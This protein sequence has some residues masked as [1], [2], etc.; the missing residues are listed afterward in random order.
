MLDD[1]SPLERV[2][3]LVTLKDTLY[4]LAGDP[5]RLGIFETEPLQ[6]GHLTHST[7]GAG[8]TECLFYIPGIPSFERHPLG[9]LVALSSG[10]D[11]AATGALFRLSERRRPDE[12]PVLF[13]LLPLYEHL[14]ERLEVLDIQSAATNGTS[15]SLLNGGRRRAR[16][17]LDL[18]ATAACLA[19]GAPL[20]PDLVRRV[21]LYDE[22]DHGRPPLDWGDAAFIDCSPVPDR[23]VFFVASA[24]SART[25]FVGEMDPEGRI[26]AVVALEPEGEVVGLAA[27]LEDD[28]VELLFTFTSPSATFL[29]CEA[30]FSPSGLGPAS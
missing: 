15:I 20:G 18:D 24:P 12:S 17:D 7:G 16:I 27:Q 8:D 2:R 25:A 26:V 3:G 14:R 30:R 11:R 28:S 29:L 13:D 9:A 22:L 10:K 4:L 19:R 5:A 23:R 21:H 1:R 6:P